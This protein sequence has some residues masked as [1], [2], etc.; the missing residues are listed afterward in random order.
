MAYICQPVHNCGDTRGR[1]RTQILYTI[2]TTASSKQ[3]Y[4]S[5]GHGFMTSA[6][7][8]IGHP[9][10]H[11]TG[12]PINAARPVSVKRSNRKDRRN[13]CRAV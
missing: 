9:F 3:D 4:R 6:R 12:K 7:E 11:F 13:E 2:T 5:T 8:L 10:N 1:R